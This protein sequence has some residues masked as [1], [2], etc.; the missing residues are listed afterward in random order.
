[1]V[2]LKGGYV[3][4]GNLLYHKDDFSSPRT[5]LNRP[6]NYWHQSDVVTIPSAT[7]AG[8]TAVVGWGSSV[9]QY[10]LAILCYNWGKHQY[11]GYDYDYAFIN[12][13]AAAEN[14]TNPI[15]QAM[16]L[17]AGCYEY[18]LGTDV[19]MSKA[20]YWR[21]E[22]AKYDDEDAQRALTPLFAH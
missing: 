21:E 20:R 1:M 17:L 7:P 14:K 13:T 19:D 11:L 2:L 5:T 16:T 18:G 15:P 4:D 3:L 6:E 12:L 8:Y 10:D 9:D 22:A